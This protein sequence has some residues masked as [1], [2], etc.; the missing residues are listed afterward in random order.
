MEM[1]LKI[2]NFENE[3][4]RLKL[5][6]D[7]LKIIAVAHEMLLIRSRAPKK[8]NNFFHHCFSC[9]TSQLWKC[10]KTDR[11]LVR[12]TLTADVC[13]ANLFA[14]KFLLHLSSSC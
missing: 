6:T 4:N 12:L 13:E 9:V 2:E 1:K 5:R 14:H 3:K 11:F 10:I 8:C 7:L